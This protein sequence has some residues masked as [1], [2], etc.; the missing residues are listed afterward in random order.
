[1]PR[2]TGSGWLARSR[3]YQLL[4]TVTGLSCQWSGLRSIPI[5]GPR[6][7]LETELLA[8]RHYEPFDVLTRP[9]L[10]PHA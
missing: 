6:A 10:G 4:V 3:S 9:Q 8:H 2:E 1:M 7:S 5:G